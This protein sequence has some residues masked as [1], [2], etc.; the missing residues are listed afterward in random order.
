M[1]DDH[2]RFFED[3]KCGDVR[4]CYVRDG[5]KE[6]VHRVIRDGAGRLWTNDLGP[7]KYLDEIPGEVVGLVPN[8]QTFFGMSS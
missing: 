7:G 3:L 1:N 5:E 6:S 8:S 4:Y 2:K